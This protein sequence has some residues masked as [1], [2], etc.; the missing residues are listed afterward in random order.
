[1]AFNYLNSEVPPGEE[2]W[3]KIYRY[4]P[5]SQSWV[6]L[7][8]KLYPE[9]NLAVATL[10]QPGAGLYALMSSLEIPL[11]G[12]GWDW[13]G[14]PV[15]TDPLRAP[16]DALKSINGYYTT[17]YWYNGLDRGDPW[18]MYSV[19]A[20]RW[21]NDLKEMRFGEAYR[22]HLKKSVNLYLKGSD[23]TLS[24]AALLELPASY[25]GAVVASGLTPTA[26][27]PVSAWVDG[28]LCGASSTLLEN[29][30]MVYAI[31]V[32]ADGPDTPGCGAPGK[33]ITFQVGEQL[34]PITAVWENSDVHE[35]LLGNGYSLYLPGV[36]SQ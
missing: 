11:A 10:P 35:F 29:G 24:S 16:A 22:I 28:A 6:L 31:N 8:T 15:E 26:G 33:I 14:Y 34:I 19:K 18:K 7:K 9:N 12:P 30:E 17:V 2:N 21:A 27:L 13:F 5:T 1:M 20:P 4:D 32:F 23:N 3:L 25:F 36:T